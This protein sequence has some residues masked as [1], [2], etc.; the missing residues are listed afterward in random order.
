M[1]R[2][3]AQSKTS[4][5]FAPG[6]LYEN[7]AA[8]VGLNNERP[9]ND[10]AAVGDISSGDD[11][12]GKTRDLAILTAPG[13][14]TFPIGSLKGKFYWD[15][16]WNINGEER[17]NDIYDLFNPDPEFDRDGAQSFS[18]QDALAWLVG[19]ELSAGKGKGAWSLF[20]NYRETGIAS[21]DP[22]INDS[23]FALSN[24]NFRGF[25]FGGTYGFTD[26]ITFGVTGFI[27]YN[28]D[29]DLYGGEATSGSA[30]ARSNAINTVQVDL[31]WKF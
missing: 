15:F 28:L 13:D 9:F 25:K 12:L 22:N 3:P 23:D 17:Y 19:F 21:V 7:A 10:A 24:L 30:I 14:F 18:D 31:N 27:T 8:L 2:L 20:V 11:V 5:T 6:F 26:F 1:G 29:G 4:I 16:A